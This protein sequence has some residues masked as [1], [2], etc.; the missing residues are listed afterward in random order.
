[1]S[2][3]RTDCP[4]YLQV[5][6]SHQPV[7]MRRDMQEVSLTAYLVVFAAFKPLISASLH[8]LLVSLSLWLWIRRHC[9]LFDILKANLSSSNIWTE[10]NCLPN[11]AQICF[12]KVLMLSGCY[13]QRNILSL[14]M[15]NIWP[16]GWILGAPCP[17]MFLHGEPIAGRA[18][19]HMYTTR[20]VYKCAWI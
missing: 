16:S 20:I 19:L 4:H 17:S 5:I 6:R 12:S 13:S 8:E 1:M 18:H 14:T 10:L 11:V 9:C 7:C 3:I 2:G 15:T